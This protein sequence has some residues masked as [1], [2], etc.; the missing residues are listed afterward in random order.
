M[1]DLKLPDLNHVMLAGRLTRDV[2]ARVLPSGQTLVK[3]GLAV[4]RVYKA[5][6]GDKQEEK[7][8]INVTCW[9][10]TAEYVRD[11]IGKGRP[12]LVEGRLKMD[13]WEDKTTSQ[14]RSA[15]EITAERIQALDWDDKSNGAA[16]RPVASNS[17]VAIMGDD[18]APF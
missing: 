5:K 12:V 8:F 11:H 18:E 6:S 10:K 16:K 3:F 17:E 4:S 9:G 1:A 15:I 13:E 7:L 2:E 14:R